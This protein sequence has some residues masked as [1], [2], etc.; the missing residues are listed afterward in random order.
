MK[1]KKSELLDN[2]RFFLHILSWREYWVVI[3]VVLG[4]VGVWLAIWLALNLPN[5]WKSI[6]VYGIIF[7][8]AALAPERKDELY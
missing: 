3:G 8:L 2:I 5:P 6:I 4:I 7:S 1:G